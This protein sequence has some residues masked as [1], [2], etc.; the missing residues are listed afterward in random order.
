MKWK[1]LLVVHEW[2][3]I[4]FKIIF[5]MVNLKKSGP[6][7]LLFKYRYTEYLPLTM[8]NIP[9]YMGNQLPITGKN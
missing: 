3:Q 7:E 6:I 2:I 8:Q 4:Y 9:L 5:M 1:N